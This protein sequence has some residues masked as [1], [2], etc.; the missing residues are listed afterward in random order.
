MG[1]HEHQPDEE[2]RQHVRKRVAKCD[3]QAASSQFGAGGDVGRLLHLQNLGAHDPSEAGPM[4]QRDADDHAPETLPDGVGDQDEQD[5]M[6]HAHHEVDEPGDG[7]IDL[8][9][10]KRRRAAERKRDER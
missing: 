7:G 8:A 3:A 2:L 5:D 9:A 6:R 10:A 4:R 1:E